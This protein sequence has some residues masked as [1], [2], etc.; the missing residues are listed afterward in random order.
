ML[1]LPQEL[2]LALRR[3]RRTPG[4]TAL[5]V[6]TLALGL[7]AHVA[8]FSLIDAL[9]LQPLPL[10]DADR[11]V[12]VYET[13][14]G[15]GFFPLSF[16]DYLDHR[17]RAEVFDG[18][19]AHYPAAPLSFE[20]ADGLV[21]IN[22][23][24][25]SANYF[26]LLGVEPERGRF[27][28]PEDDAVP[29]G[30]PVAVVSNALWRSRLGARDDA[31]GDVVRLNGT[32][33]TVVGVA[34]EGFEGVRL[35]LPSEVWIPTSMSRIGYRW[36]DT[37]DRDCTSLNLIGRLKPGR[38]LEQAAS[39]MTV[40]ARR[41]REENPSA[42]AGDTARGLIVTPLE[43]LHPALRPSM[44]RLSG[45]LL[46]AVTLLVL[47]AG[48]N[49]AG[50]LV[51]RG[52]AYR[53][54]IAVR[55]ALGASRRR[56]VSLFQ[57]ETILLTLAGGALGLLVAGWLGRLVALFYPGRV[58]LDLGPGTDATVLLYTAGLCLVTGLI[59]GLVP[60]LQSS[61][62]SLVPALKDQVSTGVRGRPRVLGLLVIFQVALSLVLLTGSGLLIRSLA[63]TD[64]FGSVD[65]ERVATLRLRPRLVGYAPPRARAFT[66]AV[67]R[68]LEALPGVRSVSLGSG[69]AHLPF[70][71]PVRVAR[72]DRTTPN[73]R[74]GLEALSNE[75]APRFLATNGISLLRGRDFDSRDTV[76]GR[77]VA[78]INRTLA[79]TL[80]PEGEPVGRLLT[81]DDRSFEV[82]GVVADA[83]YR[84]VTQGA[85]LEVYT[86]YWQ[87]PDRVDARLCVRTEGD[88]GELLPTLR[89]AI[90]EIDP[91][92]PVTETSTLKARLRSEFAS[93]HL[94]G[95]VLAVSGALAA[96]L[97]AV[98][99]FGV[100]ALAVTRR[101][102]EVGIRMALGAGQ[103][104]VV[105]AIV[106]EVLGLVGV[107]LGLG[108]LGSVAVN[109]S[110]A[111]YLYGVSAYD[112][113]TFA[114]ALLLL[115]LTAVVAA[116][117]PARRAA[118]VDPQVA[119]RS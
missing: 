64:R 13:R 77:P 81:L 36:C 94:A 24:V 112:P 116:W 76:D 7:G 105:T 78:L 83:T 18:L 69:L 34:P 71:N 43:G 108:L 44:M 118:R 28:L 60:G 52:L 55:L 3:L 10:P 15:A 25:V 16:P 17:A 22:G 12:G 57:T 11:L 72:P 21:E 1:T 97:S 109:R 48:A 74:P 4:F 42:A 89:R 114:A 85:A 29:G 14:D 67:V 51:G 119:L 75:V 98:G 113:L 87:D 33:F 102:R 46:A 90:F 73:V 91:Q 9:F 23:S 54:E 95:R 2:R 5:A 32:A 19:A 100:L 27:F 8:I 61:R 53:R 68:R 38:T 107:A 40:L 58:P 26:S 96:F 110:L 84:N 62:P 39:E 35:G 82:V 50:L 86:A 80:W 115:A 49:L 6:V 56:V 117:W 41:V 31:I 88:A 106:G 92:V 20:T 111:H 101:T 37:S 103:W 79:E 93:V 59:V 47:I 65:P 104:Q 99:L 30:H 66:R 63:T 70:G 45:L